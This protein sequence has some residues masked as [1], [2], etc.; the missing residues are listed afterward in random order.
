MAGALLCCRLSIKVIPNAPQ[1]QITGW[2][3]DSLKIK[4]HA[5]PVEGRA[6]DELCAFLAESL[7]LQTRAV[8]LL[9]GEKSR[10]KWVQITGLDLAAVR[11]RVAA[12][13]EKE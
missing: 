3:G 13:Q 9:R 11:S 1:N 7:G 2:L 8:T 12:I 4:V 6:N 10:Q 5:P